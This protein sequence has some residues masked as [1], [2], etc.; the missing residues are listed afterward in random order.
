MFASLLAVQPFKRKNDS[1]HDAELQERED[2]F[3]H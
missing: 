3:G 2:M 1:Q